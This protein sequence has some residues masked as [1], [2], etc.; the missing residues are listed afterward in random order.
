MTLIRY[1]LKILRTKTVKIWI[2][3]LTSHMGWKGWIVVV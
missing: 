3:V 2:N 1:I